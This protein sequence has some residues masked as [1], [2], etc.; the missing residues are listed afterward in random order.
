MP[1][2]QSCRCVIGPDAD[3]RRRRTQG[4]IGI[5]LGYGNCFALRSVVKD[6]L[7][8]S[9]GSA[10]GRDGINESLLLVTNKAIQPSAR[11]GLLLSADMA[12]GCQAWDKLFVFTNTNTAGLLR[13]LTDDWRPRTWSDVE[14]TDGWS[15]LYGR[16]GIGGHTTRG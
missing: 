10:L 4:L 7:Q 2:Q 1:G 6:G 3:L 16:V 11:D 12:R 13:R 9:Q 5:A 14:M 15:L 8:A